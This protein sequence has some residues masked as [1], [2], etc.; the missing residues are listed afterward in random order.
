MRKKNLIVA[1]AS[2]C[3]AASLLAGLTAQSALA[4][5]ASLPHSYD[6]VGVGSDTIQDVMNSFSYHYNLDKNPTN[7]LYSWNATGSS[8]ITPKYQGQTITRPDGSGAGI[9]ALE[10]YSKS[11]V[12]FAR[13]SSGP[14]A[15]D[16]S[17]ITYVALAGDAVGVTV[18][19]N[20]NGPSN[21]SFYD[22]KGIYSCTTRRWNQLA[23]N[24]G[25]SS[26]NIVPVLPQANSGTRKFFLSAIGVT[27]PGSCV[28]S[29]PQENEGT[30]SNLNT[31]NVLFPY[32]ISKYIAQ[33]RGAS[34]DDRG[35]LKL[36]KVSS[37]FPT[38]GTG[39]SLAINPSLNAKLQRTVY[40]VVR[41]DTSTIDG[42]P[43]YL[44]PI[45]SA[46]GYTCSSAGDSVL[47]YYGFRV[48]SSCG[49][50]ITP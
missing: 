38:T 39:S 40:D 2:G 47:K 44:R 9:T 48:L 6:I 16:P 18:H 1:A 33:A 23:G 17:S 19:K 46:S 34:H 45:F 20:T 27:T 15:S 37:V 26:Q 4:D 3:V 32:A 10:T 8:T 7:K 42:I 13:S 22:L 21:I 43:S 29:G 30:N 41:T 24:S 25:G 12:D 11:T 31:P 35:V 28:V 49:S 5:P 50:T 14:S 36:V